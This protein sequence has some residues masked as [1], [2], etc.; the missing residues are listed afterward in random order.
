M[1]PTVFEEY[2]RE[3]CIN[4][5]FLISLGIL[6]DSRYDGDSEYHLS[7]RKQQPMFHYFD[8]TVSFVVGVPV[9]VFCVV[10]DIL[11]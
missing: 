6:T 2:S 5:P 9:V 1:T 10:L 4:R 8:R 11:S 7:M 3:C